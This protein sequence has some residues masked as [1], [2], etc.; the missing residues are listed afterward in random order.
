MSSYRVGLM[1]YSVRDACAADL[2]GTLR[3]VA[4]LG[5]QGV[6]IVDLFGH[7]PATVVG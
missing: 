4:A 6:E 2:E 7:S 5:Y 3:E 1:L